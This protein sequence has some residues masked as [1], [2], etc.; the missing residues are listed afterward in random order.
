MERKFTKLELTNT[1]LVQSVELNTFNKI[2][3]TSRQSEYMDTTN[4]CV[5]TS[6]PATTV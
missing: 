5:A 3:M 2:N 6:S 1:T 4:K